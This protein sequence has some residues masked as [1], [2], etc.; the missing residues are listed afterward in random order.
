MNFFSRVRPGLT[1]LELL[2][3]LA[4]L[5]GVVSAGSAWTV[6][7]S[8]S[9]QSSIRKS[10][11]VNVKSRVIAVLQQDL[12]GATPSSVVVKDG[13]LEMVTTHRPGDPVPAWQTVRWKF[14]SAKHSLV[15][16]ETSARS[17]DARTQA[18]DGLI[19][20]WSVQLTFVEK[21][22]RDQQP[23]VLTVEIAFAGDSI[24]KTSNSVVVWRREP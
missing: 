5:A 4:I 15:R 22:G 21:T 14:D 3:A 16:E 19:D 7:L 23:D 12:D 8:R 18:I 13:T 24:G 11:Q 1:L 10:Q 9:A 20:A 17:E 2:A 6:T